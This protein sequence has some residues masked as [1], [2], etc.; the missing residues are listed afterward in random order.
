M[1]VPAKTFGREHMLDVGRPDLT[2]EEDFHRWNLFHQL[3]ENCEMRIIVNGVYNDM[4]EYCRTEQ[5]YLGGGFKY[6]FWFESD[7]AKLKFDKLA[8][9]IW[10]TEPERLL[11]V[12]DSRLKFTKVKDEY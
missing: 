11:S 10:K 8:R 7:E 3:V 2:C 12:D 1:I 4:K 9:A 5:G 6:C